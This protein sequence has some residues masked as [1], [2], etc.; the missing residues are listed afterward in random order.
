MNYVAGIYL[1]LAVGMVLLAAPRLAT[2]TYNVGLTP[3]WDATGAGLV[4]AAL[5]AAARF[6]RNP[7]QRATSHKT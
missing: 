7:H 2:I 6:R 4:T 5:A 3:L 1:L